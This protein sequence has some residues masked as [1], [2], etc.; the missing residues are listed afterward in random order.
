MKYIVAKSK[1]EI[2]EE[3]PEKE[4]KEEKKEKELT[5]EDIN[6]LIE[7]DLY[8]YKEIIEVEGTSEKF[9]WNI[10]TDLYDL[11][12]KGFDTILEGYFI[13]SADFI[14]KK[15]NLSYAKDYI[16]ELVEY[17]HDKMTEEEKRDLVNKII[18]L[19]ELV[20]DFSFETPDIYCIY[21]YVL[22]LFIENEIIRGKELEKIFEAKKEC[23][24]DLNI[25]NKMFLNISENVIDTV[26][27]KEFK[28]INFL[29]KQTYL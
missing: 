14:E 7:K 1:E 4:E 10:T 28:E 22:R 21:E 29:K 17:Y 15:G 11:K 5:Q 23:K 24:D 6:K 3:K 13:S 18:D 12:L 25:F 8:N 16:K 27:L 9:S 2:K 26:Y 19:F 20:K